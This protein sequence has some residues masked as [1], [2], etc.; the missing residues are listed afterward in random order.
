MNQP[1]NDLPPIQFGPLREALLADADNL[2]E[3]W[4]PG[5][6]FDGHEYKCAD[7]S[8]GHGHSCSVNVKTGKWATLPLQASKATT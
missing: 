3:R 6:Q 8:G 4:L 1:R 5:G 7:L 2:V